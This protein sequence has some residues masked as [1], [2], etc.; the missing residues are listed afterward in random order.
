MNRCFSKEVIQMANTS[1]NSCSASL[2]GRKM[3]MKATMRSYLTPVKMAMIKKT[4]DNKH[5]RRCGEIR[6]P[7]LVGM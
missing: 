6:I 4:K 5:W 3:Q 2:M 7:L 1:M